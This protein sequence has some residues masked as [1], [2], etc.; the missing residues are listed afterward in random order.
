MTRCSAG[1]LPAAG[2]GAFAIDEV[3]PEFGEPIALGGPQ[4]HTLHGGPL[5]IL[6]EA[7]AWDAVNDVV[8][9]GRLTGM[10]TYMV[11]PARITPLVTRTRVLV[12][13]HPIVDCRVELYDDDGKGKICAVSDLQFLRS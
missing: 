11:A 6:A 10:T 8:G 2:P 1:C 3:A 13:A 7:S 9:A 12:G 4:S 5:Q